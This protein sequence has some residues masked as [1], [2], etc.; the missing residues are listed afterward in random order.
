MKNTLLQN[1][2][3][4]VYEEDRRIEREEKL[5]LTQTVENPFNTV[6]NISS[7]IKN[8]LSDFKIKESKSPVNHSQNKCSTSYKN[9]YLDSVQ[10]IFEKEVNKQKL[11]KLEETKN[12]SKINPINDDIRR[13]YRK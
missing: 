1:K 10:I 6:Y 2:T 7:E 3:D 12:I 8:D 13:K 11:K 9:S 4:I 5:K